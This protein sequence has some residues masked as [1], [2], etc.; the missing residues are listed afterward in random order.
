[1]SKIPTTYDDLAVTDATNSGFALVCGE[2]YFECAYVDDFPHPMPGT[3]IRPQ[4]G[5]IA[6]FDENDRYL[7]IAMTLNEAKGIILEKF[8]RIE[9]STFLS[10]PA[11]L[12]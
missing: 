9:K 4:A 3:H 6:V 5:A 10:L 12:S 8:H 7:D 11:T 1:M 2:H